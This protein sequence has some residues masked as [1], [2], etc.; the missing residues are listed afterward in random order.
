[1][2]LERR[3]VREDGLPERRE[4]ARGDVEPELDLR[5]VDRLAHGVLRHEARRRRD[6][7]A[8]VEA[9]LVARLRGDDRRVHRRLDLRRHVDGRDR[10]RELGHVTEATHGGLERGEVRLERVDDG[11]LVARLGSLGVLELGLHLDEARLVRGAEHVAHELRRVLGDLLLDGVEELGLGDGALVLLA[12]PDGRVDPAG[13]LAAPADLLD[14]ERERLVVLHRESNAPVKVLEDVELDVAVLRRQVDARG[15]DA[16]GLDVLV[17]SGGGGRRNGLAR[18]L[19]ASKLERHSVGR[20]RARGE[21]EMCERNWAVSR[22]PRQRVPTAAW[23][24]SWAF[25]GIPRQSAA[26]RR[27]CAPSRPRQT[28][29][30]LSFQ[31]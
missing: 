29:C 8:K 22:G 31:E 23:S 7:D 15:L 11:R 2:D 25:R 4:H 28:S 26:I 12:T 9:A 6:D 19:G 27:G 18:D 20:V 13:A 1:M 17:E 30:R 10:A 14:A 3:E 16:G 24:L 5:V 21:R